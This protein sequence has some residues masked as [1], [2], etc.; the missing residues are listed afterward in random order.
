MLCTSLQQGENKKLD[1]QS[2]HLETIT[3]QKS[4]WEQQRE[5]TIPQNVILAG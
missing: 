5:G 1:S 4:T 2:P 3:H